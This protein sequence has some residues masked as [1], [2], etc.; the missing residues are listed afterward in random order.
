MISDSVLAFVLQAESS[1]AS[2]KVSSIS[3]GHGHGAQSTEETT[4]D[5]DRMG[6][7]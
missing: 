5:G 7:Y 4:A 3:C 6:N 2:V 1:R